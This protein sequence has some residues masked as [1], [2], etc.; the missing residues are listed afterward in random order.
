[1]TRTIRFALVVVVLSASSLADTG[2]AQATDRFQ[3]LL[4]VQTLNRMASDAATTKKNR[5]GDDSTRRDHDA[6]RRTPEPEPY[7]RRAP[8]RPPQ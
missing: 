2:G 8:G 3:K 1:M 4:Q 7:N 6:D 5:P